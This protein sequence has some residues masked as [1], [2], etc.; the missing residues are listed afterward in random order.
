MKLSA[1]RGSSPKRWKRR[2]KK[3]SSIVDL[4]P[5]NIKV[6]PEG[7]VKVLDFGLSAESAAEPLTWTA[8]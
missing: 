7:K 5:D 8:L 1:W 6:T 2:T 3:A 4:K